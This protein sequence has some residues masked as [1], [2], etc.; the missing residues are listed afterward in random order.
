MESKFIISTNGKELTATFADN[1]SAVAF[2]NLIAEAP[3]TVEMSDYGDFEK[4]GSIG[5]DLPTND[6]RVTT[7]PGD[8]ILYLGNNITIYYDV[9]TWSF[10][11]LGRVDGNPTRESM[12]A[13]L[14]KGKANVTFSLG[15]GSAG[16]SAADSDAAPLKVTVSGMTV[17]VAGISADKDIY[18]YNLDGQCVYQGPDHKFTLS[19]SGIYMVTDGYAKAKIM[20]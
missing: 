14:G 18:V 13:V 3:L 4:V 15:K 12:L 6:T 1:S 16:I 5:R 19:E 9:N 17:T 20:L 10:T 11:R 2:R 8:V 7:R